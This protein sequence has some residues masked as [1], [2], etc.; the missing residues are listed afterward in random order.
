MFHKSIQPQ[1]RRNVLKTAAVTALGLAVPSI[2]TSPSKAAIVE[3]RM[4][5]RDPGDPNRR[6]LFDPP[7]VRASPGDTVRFISV[8]KGHNT[9]N[10][11]G[12]VPEGTVEWKSKLSRDFELKFD[13]P[14]VYAHK[15]TPH[16]S[17]GMVGIIIVEGEGWDTNLAAAKSVKQRGKAKK[18]FARLWQE[19]DIMMADG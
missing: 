19:L 3:V 4:L 10:I 18:Q 15:C 7:L 9:Q 13:K 6:N 2:F 11:K 8:E 1:T 17:A 5:S 12:M 16:Y 14:G